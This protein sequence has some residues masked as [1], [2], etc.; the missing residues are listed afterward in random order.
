MGSSLLVGLGAGVVLALLGLVG[1][2]ITGSVDA[3]R[4]LVIADMR[5]VILEEP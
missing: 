4:Q 5:S 2:G 3:V 1:D